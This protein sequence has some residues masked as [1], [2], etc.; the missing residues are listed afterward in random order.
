MISIGRERILK[1]T[2]VTVALA[3]MA[4]A[5]YAPRLALAQSAAPAPIAA[6]AT[7]IAPTSMSVMPAQ[8]PPEINVRARDAAAYES[9]ETIT[10]LPQRVFRQFFP[11]P[12]TPPES[13]RFRGLRNSIDDSTQALTL[14]EAV[15]IGLKNNPSVLA[16]SLEPIAATEGVRMSQATFDPDFLVT[17]DTNKTVLPSTTALEVVGNALVIKNY[18]WNFTLNKVLRPTNGIISLFFDNNKQTTNNLFQGVVPAYTPNLGVSLTQPLLRNFGWKFSTISVRFAQSAQRATQLSYASTLSDFVQS[19]GDDYWT[20]VNAREN[21]EVARAALDFNQDLVRQNSISVKVGTLA[22]IDLQEAQS[23]AATAQANVYSAEANLKDAQAQL[24]EDVML[25]PRWTVVPQKI[26][27]SER[28]HPSEP[29]D[30]DEERLLETAIVNSPSLAAMREQIRSQML[31]VRYQNNQLLPSLSFITQFSLTSLGG[32]DVC[33]PSFGGTS[34]CIQG[35]STVGGVTTKVPGFRPD[36]ANGYGGALNQMFGFH[37][38]T[39]AFAASFELPMDNAPII[40]QLAQSKIL[41]R[42]MRAQYEAALSQLVVQVESARATVIAAVKRAKA[43]QAAT[44]YAKQALHDE[45]VRFRV[46]MATTH[47]LLQFQETEVSA[48]GN[49]V[50]AETDLEKSKLAVR[51]AEFT[52]L[53]SFQIHFQMQRQDPMPWYAKF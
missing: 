26:E 33:T 39:Y 10:A 47:D 40:A 42:Q 1:S 37:Y 14:K 21:L 45:E 15:Y 32:S 11:A 27:P 20:V 3:I 51:H 38:Y 25:S 35:T 28:P 43:A 36:F 16:A 29:I 8:N 19:V 4:G 52:L 6:P 24:R 53:G 12:E 5:I 41:S 22:P 50:Q 44:D 7:A 23:S 13:R 30:F 46:G 34:N 31:Q 18:D 48:E 17:L 49:Q 9:D 2:L